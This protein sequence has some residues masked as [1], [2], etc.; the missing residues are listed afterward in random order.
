MTYE[1]QCAGDSNDTR[2]TL[3]AR[4]GDGEER[5]IQAGVIA[6]L[7]ASKGIL[8]AARDSIDEIKRLRPDGLA[9]HGGTADLVANLP[10]ALNVLRVALSGS[11]HAVERI[12]VGVGI[13]GALDAWHRGELTSEQVI[14]R[15]VAVAKVIARCGVEVIVLNGEGKWALRAGSKRTSAD[16]RALAAAVG[17]AYKDHAPECVLALSSFGALGYHADVRALIEGITPFCSIFTG[18]SYAARAGEVAKGVLPAVLERDEKSQAATVRQ[19]W[20]RADETAADGSDESAD[21]LDRVPTIQAHKTHPSDLATI[22]VERS[23]LLVWSLPT[24]SDGG[25][26]DES[27]L[28][29]LQAALAIRSAYGS[30]RDA[31]VE[32]QQMHGLDAN[33]RVGP[34]TRAKALEAK[35]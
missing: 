30:G 35:P 32:F 21:D 24:I 8:A 4:S 3:H 12:W 33:G 29:A 6:Y 19:G 13:D 17:K 7:W 1:D 26:A 22:A 10:A 23:L 2:T 16:V 11:E 5:L 14:G 28:Q 9:I 25:R 18:Q 31:I 27:G 34:A 15:H 20:M